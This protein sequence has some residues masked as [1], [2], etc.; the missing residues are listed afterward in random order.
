MESKTFIKKNLIISAETKENKFDQRNRN[1]LS[2]K[3]SLLRSLKL[4]WKTSEK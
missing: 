2:K 3:K 1:F 4:I